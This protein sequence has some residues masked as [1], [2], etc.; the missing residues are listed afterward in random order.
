MLN[1]KPY[2]AKFVR[3][4][5]TYHDQ[6]TIPYKY[7]QFGVVLMVDIVGFSAL[8]TLATEKG[9]SS[10]E[11]IALE[12]GTYMGEC[13]EIIE[14][15]GGDVVKFLGDAVLVCFQP[16]ITEKMN[17]TGKH[18]HYSTSEKISPQQQ[19]VLVQRAVECGMEL[20]AK[21]SHYRVYLTPEERS[22]HR[23]SSTEETERRT[24]NIFGQRLIPFDHLNNN[25]NDNNNN[26]NNNNNNSKNKNN[27]NEKKDNDNENQQSTS[28]SS[29]SS[30]SSV[31]SSSLPLDSFERSD[32][33]NSSQE[34][35][36][37][38]TIWDCIPFIKNRR[39]RV[40]GQRPSI[41]SDRSGST[42]SI[43]L[44]LHIALSCG[45]ISNIILGDMN[46]NASTMNNSI[47]NNNISKQNQKSANINNNNSESPLPSPTSN[48]NNN[49]RISIVSYQSTDGEEVH[50]DFFHYQGR[51]EYAICG[52][53]VEAL[54]AAIS[55]AK[56]GELCL[57]HTAFNA[58]RQQ[59]IGFNYERRKNF[60]VI[61]GSQINSNQLMNHYY[62]YGT[63]SSNNGRQTPSISKKSKRRYKFTNGIFHSSSST[64]SLQTTNNNNQNP[65]PLLDQQ[66]QPL[67]LSPH[68]I[69]L[70]DNTSTQLTINGMHPIQVKFDNDG[71]E[72]INPVFLKY[73]NRSALY[74]L[75]QSTND[76]FPAQF[77]DVT[78]MFISL[79]KLNPAT[80]NGLKLAQ[81]AVYLCVKTLVKYEGTLQQFAVDDKGATL[82]AVF[83]L[84]PLSH[85]REAIFAA[86][87]A[88][89]LRDAYLGLFPDF[90]IALSTGTIFNAV[91]PQGCP[92][93]RDP[94]IAG[95]TIILAVRMLKFSFAVQN[96]VC[97]LATKQQI[98]ALCEYDEH[99]DNLVKGKV[100]PVPI[101][102]IRRFGIEKT[103]RI[104]LPT[105]EK[106]SDFIGYKNE[107]E[108]AT[109]FLD[110]WSEKPD[111]HLLIISGPSGTGKS[112]FCNALGK[113][114]TSYGFT[115]CWSSS[116]EVEKSSKY[117]L[118]KNLL[119]SLFEI[120]DSEVIPQNTQNT[121]N[122]SASINHSSTHGFSN[123]TN[124]PHPMDTSPTSSLTSITYPVSNNITTTTATNNN[125]NNSNN[126]LQRLTTYSS[127]TRSSYGA[128]STQSPDTTN[129][130]LELILRC[131]R[132]C[133]EDDGFLP[134]FKIIFGTIGDMDEN[135]FTRRLDGRGRDI[136]L[137]GV[138]TRMVKYVSEIIPVVLVCDDVQWIDSASIRILQH[139]HEHSQRT[140]LLLATRPIKDYNVT[141]IN[142]F[143][144]TGISEEI[145][146]N[147][148]GS[149]DIVD[150][151]LRML[152]AGV[153]KVSP[154]IVRVIQKRTGGNPLYVKNMAI[155]L[156]DFNHVTIFEG[157]LVPSNNRFD[158]KELLQNL[159]Y[160]RIIKMQFDRLDPNFQE[161]LTIASCLDQFFTIYEVEA[162]IKPNNVI[163]KENDPNKIRETIEKY[164]V[165]HFLQRVSESNIDNNISSNGGSTGGLS[166]IN[167]GLNNN[168]LTQNE[169]YAFA[170][171][172]IPKSIYD[173]VSYET[174]IDLHRRLA[175]YYENQLTKDNYPELLGKVARHYLRTDMFE[176]QL[177]Y[178]E[179]LADL[180]IRSYL[181]PE[182]TSNLEDM[183]KILNDNPEIA[184]RF[185]PIHQSDIYRR[186]GVCFTMR[187]EL[188]KGERYLRMALECL[189]ESW[190]KSQPE[191]LFKCWKNRFTQYQNRRWKLVWKFNSETRKQ[192]GHRV[193]EIMAQLSNIYFYTGKGRAFVYTCLVGLNACERLNEIG[194][195]YTL[196][197][198]RTSLIC[199]LG[200]R[201]EHSIFYITKALRYMDDK[202]DA[203]TLTIC[204]LLC[205]AAG[206]FKNSKE[207]LYQ[208][209]DAVKTL[210]VVTDCQSFYR[211]AGLIIT[212]LI[213]EG[214]LDQSPEGLSVL[215]QMVDTA[216]SNGDYEAEI[217]LG[218]YNVGNA[219][220]MGRLNECEPFVALLEHH[221]KQAA[222]YN[223]I[224]IHG[225]L[226]YYYA[227]SQNYE[228]AKRHARHI[229]SILPSLTVTPNIF[230]IF[231]LIFATMG[232]YCLVEDGQVEMVT[233][234][235]S[236][237]FERFFLGIA[238]LNHAFQQVKFWE[239][240]QPCLYL[241]RALPYISTGRT[242]EGYM[243][244]RHGIFEMHFIHEI[245]FLKAYYW[246]CMGKYA[247]TP[248]DRID[249]TRRAEQDL[250]DLNIP[251]KIYINPDPA[252]SYT[253]EKPADMI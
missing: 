204:A 8:T 17:I 92:Y 145:A 140:M 36:M 184:F 136:L 30:S 186:L 52:P 252:N 89:E 47:S 146:L 12:I 230:P 162:I 176:K 248:K 148:L 221:L 54:E 27:N 121:R 143:C 169:T 62:H 175:I 58:L 188:S 51:L 233:S 91:L 134:L 215:K 101:Y 195:N 98:G 64:A 174:R 49:N 105:D 131:L 231:G 137:T 7:T 41:S 138:I 31:S 110:N 237:N 23:A 96:I 123:S 236:K 90:A 82:L 117:Y 132:K 69:S 180:N 235:D 199:W 15:Y 119:L 227:R 168:L 28:S 46:S 83:G 59:H 72:E 141:F 65:N 87:A 177:C 213:F 66:Q 242:V 120:I 39:K 139:I 74:R 45:D 245:R 210:D 144:Q 172:T 218:V 26:N 129:E 224:A 158:P 250:E 205:F 53:A 153:T 151:I 182:A 61:R 163:F 67:S 165:Y 171:I 200:D 183:V 202:H 149:D 222:D 60:Y 40:Y 112:F 122:R 225:T 201:K 211:S 56:A 228:L 246:A 219:L 126:R 25:N 226:L 42:N 106:N 113:T 179:T 20:L 220:V 150:I 198:A 185:G 212:M 29:S 97:D 9:E 16:D 160:K 76:S 232:F 206:K 48:N 127:M 109:R 128:F 116:T 43:D 33:F 166:I 196:F 214:T 10:A 11:A 115:C 5:H 178:L 100:K 108:R 191:F 234:K 50:E 71:E 241:A 104:S 203:G 208:S 155:I 37:D 133:G 229:V 194:P 93:R 2:L 240:T 111:Y 88:V 63:G 32:I 207:L 95:D 209:I 244:L 217:W 77:R 38:F 85:E 147:G 181:L 243:V 187:T 78:I 167:N 114:M 154:E 73:I 55:T 189:G 24:R 99:G 197:L 70:L 190:P 164:D 3:N 19:Y 161:F 68:D 239:F 34:Y 216:H 1:I 251:P 13:I 249:W 152:K 130:V 223:R 4:L 86:K 156:K 142:N 102:G 18:N 193:V 118:V 173:M 238:R 157:E 6:I 253:H 79:G 75:Q 170:H 57:T 247:F 22:K 81:K 80:D 135:R 21:Q 14:Q 107:M 192:I 125:N 94:A 44:D 103:K 124:N 35:S 84:P 159:D